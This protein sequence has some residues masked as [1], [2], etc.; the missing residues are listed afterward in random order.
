MLCAVFN[1]ETTKKRRKKKRGRNGFACWPKTKVEVVHQPAASVVELVR[2]AGGGVLFFCFL[3]SITMRHTA[4]FTHSSQWRWDGEKTQF[5]THS[6]Q[7]FAPKLFLSVLIIF[8]VTTIQYYTAKERKREADVAH[9]AVHHP[10]NGDVAVI[11]NDDG[12]LFER[13]RLQ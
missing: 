4:L 3:E 1:I 2:W 11:S 13:R 6:I 5:F 12:V 9:L 10:M 8:L 7:T